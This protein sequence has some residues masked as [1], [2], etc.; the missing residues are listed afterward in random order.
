[1]NV[2]LKDFLRKEIDS[3]W[4]RT[5][6]YFFLLRGDFARY[7]LYERRERKKTTSNWFTNLKQ[8][9]NIK[10]YSSKW[11]QIHPKSTGAIVTLEEKGQ[12]RR[13]SVIST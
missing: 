6:F 11:A 13:E 12:K 3:I 5:F 10:K 2:S 9:K 8:K 1:M 7:L 4:K